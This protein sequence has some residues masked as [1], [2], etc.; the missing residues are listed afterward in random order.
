MILVLVFSV[1]CNLGI[2]EYVSSC[3]VQ[4][5]MPVITVMFRLER[6]FCLNSASLFCQRSLTSA[7]ST[8][9]LGT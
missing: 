1:Y 6:E 7:V 2:L 5:A 3:D 4:T 8:G 9:H